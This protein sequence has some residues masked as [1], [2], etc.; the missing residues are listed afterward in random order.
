MITHAAWALMASS[1]VLTLEISSIAVVIDHVSKNF[2]LCRY[3]V[4]VNVPLAWNL[5]WV[6]IFRAQ[7]SVC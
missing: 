7:S 6:H 2:A 1:Q 3:W 4:I 5:C